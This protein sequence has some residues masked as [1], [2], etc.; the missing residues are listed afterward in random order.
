V[1]WHGDNPE[2]SAPTGL[3]RIVAFAIR[4]DQSLASIT[5]FLERCREHGCLPRA[6]LVDAHVAGMHGGTGKT[7]PWDRLADFHPG[8][9]L[10]LAGGLTPENVAAAVKRVRPYAVDVASGVESSP[11]RKCLDRVRRFIGEARAAAAGCSP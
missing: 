10:I 11:G 2:L 7:A 5:R 9:P 1:Q 6:V 4:D 3:E 8:V